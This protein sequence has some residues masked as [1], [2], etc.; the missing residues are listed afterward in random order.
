MLQISKQDYQ[1]ILTLYNMAVHKNYIYSQ[2]MISV[3]VC[4]YF[5]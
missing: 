3:I 2:N 4:E 5:K 1:I